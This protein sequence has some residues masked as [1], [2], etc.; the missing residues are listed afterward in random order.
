MLV[1]LG[2]TVTNIAALSGRF[3]LYVFIVFRGRSGALLRFFRIL[4]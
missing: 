4:V 3:T 2:W 1:L